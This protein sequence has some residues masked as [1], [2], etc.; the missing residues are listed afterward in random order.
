MSTSFSKAF[1]AVVA[2]AVL[3]AVQSEASVL[4][5]KTSFPKLCERVIGGTTSPAAALTKAI[6]AS[7]KQ[8]L[9]AQAEAKNS[10]ADKSCVDQCNEM[11]Q[12]AVDSLNQSLEYIKTND[13]G[14]LRSELSAV[15]TY[16]ETCNDAFAEMQ[17]KNP[18]FNTNE[19]LKEYGDNNLALAAEIN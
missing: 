13:I 8:V 4:C 17:I 12:S 3:A 19:K 10:K 11:Y 14:G 16:V 5:T 6:Q 1:L 18:F 9:N 7:L 2:V 15:I